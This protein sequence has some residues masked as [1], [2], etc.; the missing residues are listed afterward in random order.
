MDAPDVMS[1]TVLEIIRRGFKKVKVKLGRIPNNDIA[2]M[3]MIR[4]EV[5]PGVGLPV[6]A[7][8]AW[9]VADAS[10]TLRG[11]EPYRVQFCEPPAPFWD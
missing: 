10:R 2:G 4:E 7:N 11:L 9:T 1:A 6:E 5:G 3:R 8:Q